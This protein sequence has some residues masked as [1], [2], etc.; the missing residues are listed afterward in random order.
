MTRLRVLLV[1]PN[2]DGSDVGEAFV[3]FKWAEAL[4]KLADVTVLSFER[5]GRPPLA[6]QLPGARVV[7]WREPRWL[8][9]HE[10]LNAML[11]PAWPIFCRRVRHWIR[12]AAAAG[13]HFDIAHQLMPQA[14][15]YASPL[16]DSDLPHVIGPLGGIIE[17]P[18]AFKPEVGSA[19][20]YT[21]LRA[22]D[23]LR[24]AHDPWLRASYAK[25]DLVL[26]VAPYMRAALGDIPIRR[27]E[28]VLELGIDDLPPKVVRCREKGRLNLLHV[29]RG[30]RTK[31]LRDVVRSLEHLRDMP[32]VTLTSAGGGEEIEICRTEAVRMGVAD[33]V[34]FLGR[35]PREE[36]EDLYA[37][38]DV[39]VFPSFREPA[40]GVLYEA[41]RW[42]LPIVC[43][44]RGGPDWIVDESC[45]LKLDISTPEALALD[46]ASAVRTLADDPVLRVRM[47][48]AARQ[49]VA[50]EGLWTRK[51]EQMV[52]LYQETIDAR[53][54]G[55]IAAQRSL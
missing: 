43:A 2:I 44:K 19:A 27:F 5:K 47:G 42:G 45:G 7:T 50:E 32:G 13:E 12:A 8:T 1:A 49:K 29:G 23:Q 37:Q 26:G 38:A 3:A 48:D 21:R 34:R 55:A 39:F 30:V 41:M 9:R 53:S 24:I 16:V 40:G 35:V 54:T 28:T 11:K 10:R 20:W 6:E 51:A 52:G 15:R 36:V 25:A 33:R 14:A 31:G 46:V 4:A 18:K 17:T 22:L